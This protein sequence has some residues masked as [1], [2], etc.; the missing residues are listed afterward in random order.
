M[1]ENNFQDYNV[2]ESNEIKITTALKAGKKKEKKNIN[3]IK[4]T[5][6][7]KEEYIEIKKN[8]INKI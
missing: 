2:I 1:E 3:I 5:N 4:E 6:I 7:M 8:N